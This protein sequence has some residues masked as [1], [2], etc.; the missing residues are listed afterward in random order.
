[1]SRLTSSENPLEDRSKE[2]GYEQLNRDSGEWARLRGLCAFA[3]ASIEALRVC[4]AYLATESEVPLP[5]PRPFVYVSAED[6]FRPFIPARYIE[7]K[8][9]AEVH[10]E[11]MVGQHE[12]FRTV[13]IRPS[14]FAFLLSCPFLKC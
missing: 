5:G 1:M 11:D 14:M 9:E 7:T 4:E 2:G 8:R 10:L 6:I 12:Y 3:E 13:Y